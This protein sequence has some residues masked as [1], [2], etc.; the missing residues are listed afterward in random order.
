MVAKEQENASNSQ[1]DNICI[2]RPKKGRLIVNRR[3]R[4]IERICGSE[5][6][7]KFKARYP[8][9][10]DN[11]CNK[12]SRKGR[13]FYMFILKLLLGSFLFKN[14]IQFFYAGI[15]KNYRKE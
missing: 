8:Q 12:R 2:K 14:M 11:I 3:R 10:Q 5:S 4:I 15:K 9:E 7:S 6:D 13:L 1:K